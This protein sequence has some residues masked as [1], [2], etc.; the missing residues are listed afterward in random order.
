MD[1]DIELNIYES[2]MHYIGVEVHVAYSMI[3]SWENI[4]SSLGVMR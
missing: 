1:W 3:L 4:C 2:W